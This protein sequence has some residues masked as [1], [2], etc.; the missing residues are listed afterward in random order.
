MLCSKTRHQSVVNL[1]SHVITIAECLIFFIMKT[2]TEFSHLFEK[3]FFEKR[4]DNSSY[5][6]K[7]KYLNVINSLKAGNKSHHLNKFE[8]FN[9]GENE[10]LIVPVKKYSKNTYYTPYK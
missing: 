4:K 7:E 9:I 5:L 2:K 8:I 1:F 3:V 10:E 6:S